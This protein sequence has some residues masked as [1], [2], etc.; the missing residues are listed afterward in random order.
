MATRTWPESQSSP[1]T[2]TAVPTTIAPVGGTLRGVTVIGSPAAALAIRVVG[3]RRERYGDRNP[4]L[5]HPATL[6]AHHELLRAD[7]R[8]LG[9]GVRL[10]VVGRRRERSGGLQDA[11]AATRDHP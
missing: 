7:V 4:A 8:P 3:R 5:S 11:Q 2:S 10:G 1:D 9:V 6:C